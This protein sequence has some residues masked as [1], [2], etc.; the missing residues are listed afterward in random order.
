MIADERDLIEG[1]PRL[2]TATQK[3]WLW[4]TGMIVLAVALMSFAYVSGVKL[5]AD[6]QLESDKT[7]AAAAAKEW[8]FKFGPGKNGP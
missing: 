7:L 4:I 3:F 1:N 8:A 2:L 6:A 5:K